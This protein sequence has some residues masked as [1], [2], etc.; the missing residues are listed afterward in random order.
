VYLLDTSILSE[1]VRRQPNPLVVACATAVPA[2]SLATSAICV[3]E[4]RYGAMRRPDASV[5]WPRLEREIL[6]RVRVE[7]FDDAA[8]RK[9]GD[10]LA[11]LETS[12]LTIGVED[13]QI[14]GTALARG[15]VVVTA[16]TRHF[17]RVPGL[18]VEDWTKDSRRAT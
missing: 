13:S 12:R 18:A 9:T 6:T 7:P 10:I 17:T 8:A 1:F 15:L 3:M 14:A 16:N 2:A 11:A 4:L 5:F